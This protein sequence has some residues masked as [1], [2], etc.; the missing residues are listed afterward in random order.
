MPHSPP[1]SRWLC[2][3]QSGPRRPCSRLMRWCSPR[4]VSQPCP[5]S[6]MGEP[7]A[8]VHRATNS[9]FQ[10]TP[11]I[12]DGRTPPRPSLAPPGHRFN[13]RPSS[14]TGEPH[15]TLIQPPRWRFQSTPVIADGRTSGRASPHG[16]SCRFNPRPSSLTGERGR[17]FFCPS[18]AMFQSTPVIAD[19]RTGGVAGNKLDRRVSIHARHR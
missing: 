2:L 14:L 8:P 7:S 13:P 17:G 19:G 16:C 6:L 12:A 15:V 9:G 10:S 18:R 1:H 11:V 4:G 5:P 3:L